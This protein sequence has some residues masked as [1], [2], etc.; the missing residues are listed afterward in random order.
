MFCFDNMCDRVNRKQEANFQNEGIKFL[1]S[2]IKVSECV[3]LGIMIRRGIWVAWNTRYSQCPLKK[4]TNSH[5]STIS[6]TNLVRSLTFF[7]FWLII[8]SDFLRTDSRHLEI[9]VDNQELTF[10]WEIKRFSHSD[11]FFFQHEAILVWV[12][13]IVCDPILLSPVVS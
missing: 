6:F 13:N 4:N 7:V 2:S 9:R 1:K 10:R 3:K 12:W 8:V 11:K 5:L